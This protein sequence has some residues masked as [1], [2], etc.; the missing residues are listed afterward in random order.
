MAFF[1]YATGRLAALAVGAIVQTFINIQADSDF[2]LEKLTFA[3]DLA[4]AAQTNNTL[5]FPNVQVMLT[6]TGSGQQLMSAPVMIYQLFGTGLL[7]FIL[8][9]P[10]LL[11]ANSQLQITLTSNEAVNTPILDL[12]FIGRKM[13]LIAVNQ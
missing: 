11:P 5:P 1:T 8:P 2:L 4:G 6:S 10:Y 9:Y 7:P 12:A 13:Y 3:A